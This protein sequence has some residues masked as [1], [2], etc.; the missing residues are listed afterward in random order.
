MVCAL[1]VREEWIEELEGVDRGQEMRIL[2]TKSGG[3]Q[4]RIVVPA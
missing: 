4:A 1:K 3:A 2:G